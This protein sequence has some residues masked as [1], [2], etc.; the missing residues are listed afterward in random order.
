MNKKFNVIVLGG[1]V[2]GLE[3]ITRAAQRD[4]HQHFNFTLIDKSH[5][6]VW[7]P[8]LH[9]FAAGSQS[10]DE[11]SIEFLSQAKKNGYVYQPGEVIH[12]DR[13]Q[14][15]ITLAAYYNDENIEILPERYVDYDYLV[16]ALGSRSNDFNTKGVK[17]FAHVVDDLSA[18]LKF[19]K[20]LQ[21][22]LIQAAILKK[23]HHLII[24]GAG[25]TGVELS[26]EI[27][28]QMNIASS[29]SNEDLTQYL[30][31]T[32]IEA[33]DRVLP[34]FKPKVSENIRLSMEKIG[35]RVLLNS[36][37][38]EITKN[39][40]ILKGGETFIADQAVWTAGVKAPD[41]L[42]TL[43]DLD[44][45]RISQIAVNQHFQA[46]NDP[47]IFAIG[48]SSF[49]QDAPLA[50]TAQAASQQAIYLSQNF[51]AIIDQSSN[52][53]AFKYIDR[54]S[55]V[56]V[57]RYASF[58]VFGNNTAFKGLTFKGFTARV[59]HIMLYRQHQMHILGIWRSLCAWLADKFRRWSRR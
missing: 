33:G 18:A 31:L 30:D 6:H 37:V 46:I 1:G 9:T 41:V 45:S 8:M 29:Y 3:F 53:P 55:L 52:I 35:I 50:P 10:P 28:Q 19:Q 47:S 43:D 58:G 5:L 24:V 56:S 44:L 39:S 17:E 11:Q 34:T 38:E 13:Q 26:G 42:K 59:A 40:V 27:I 14:K 20:A 49:V 51:S 15:K 57:G 32:L 2:A 22:Q 21:D 16:I 48:D 36:A 4:G 54:G 25:A 23:V 12:I 7:K